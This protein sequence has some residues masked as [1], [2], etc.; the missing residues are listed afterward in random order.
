[1]LCTENKKN[2]RPISDSHIIYDEALSD[3]KMSRTRYILGNSSNLDDV[4]IVYLPLYAVIFSFQ[5]K[6]G[7]IEEDKDSEDSSISHSGSFF[8]FSARRI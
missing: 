6:I 4:G 5:G 7:S 1:M 3:N 8:L 2:K